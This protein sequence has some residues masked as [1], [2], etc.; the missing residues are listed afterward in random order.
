MFWFFGR[1]PQLHITETSRCCIY[2]VS[3]RYTQ[4]FQFDSFVLCEHHLIYLGMGMNRTE[5]IE[6]RRLETQKA[7]FLAHEQTYTL[8]SDI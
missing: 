1:N 5:N 6:Y 2:S 4:R 7:S 3:E 8:C